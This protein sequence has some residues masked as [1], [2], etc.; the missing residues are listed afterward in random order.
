MEVFLADQLIFIF[1]IFFFWAKAECLLA[2][3]EFLR[4]DQFTDTSKMMLAF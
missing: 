2:Q 1:I 4:V 3:W